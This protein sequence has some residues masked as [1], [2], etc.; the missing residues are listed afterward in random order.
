MTTQETLSY[1]TSNVS[2]IEAKPI[3]RGTLE[4]EMLKLGC[5]QDETASALDELFN[6]TRH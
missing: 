6:V 2:D 5:P 3:L 4:A 1:L